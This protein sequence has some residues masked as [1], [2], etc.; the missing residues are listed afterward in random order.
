MAVVGYS[1][2][3]GSGFVSAGDAIELVRHKKVPKA[4][5]KPAFMK[6]NTS[7]TT[8]DA[9]I[10]LQCRGREIG[11]LPSDLC[12]MIAPLLDSHRIQV[13]AKCVTCAPRLD[14]LSN[15][16][17]TLEV[18]V[19]AGAVSLPSTRTVEEP[20][21]SETAFQ[22]KEGWNGLLK[23]LGLQ[24]SQRAQVSLQMFDQLKS[25][26]KPPASSSS[27]TISLRASSE[28]Q[29]N[30]EIVSVIDLDDDTMDVELS[31]DSAVELNVETID[32]QISVD[33]E[34]STD[35][36]D[37]CSAS[38]PA[39]PAMS[40]LDALVTEQLGDS[41]LPEASPVSSF[42]SSLRAYQRQ[43][44]AWMLE[45]EQGGDLNSVKSR[46]LHPMWEEYAFPLA[47]ADDAV[48]VRQMYKHFYFNP[49]SGEFSLTFPSAAPSCTGG[50]LADEMGLGKTVMMLSLIATN[51]CSVKQLKRK[52]VSSVSVAGDSPSLRT[53]ATLIVVPM[54]LLGQWK[55]E[56]GTHLGAHTVKVYEH[57][58]P[59]RYKSASPFCNFDIVLTTYGVLASESCGPQSP[60]HTIQWH[61]VILDEAHNI[62]GRT[63]Q[64]ARAAFRLHAD[65]R[66]CLTGTPVQN[67]LDDLFSLLHFL[68]VEPWSDYL[69]WTRIVCK[70][71]EGGDPFAASLLRTI[72]SPLLLRRTKASKDKSGNAIVSLPPKHIHVH[73][74]ELTTEERDFYDALFNRSKTKFDHFVAQGK[75]LSNYASILELLLRLRQ[76]CDHP[77]LTLSRGDTGAVDDIDKLMQKFV[78]RGSEMTAT[79]ISNVVQDIRSGVTKECPVCLDPVE[80]AIVTECAHVLCREC[81]LATLAKLGSCPICRK[82]LSKESIATVPRESK[83][84]I[85]VEE[86][87]RPSA[88]LTALIERLQD[89]LA[90]GEKC[91]VFSQWTSML[92]LVQ[93]PLKKAEIPFLRLDGSLS[94][95]QRDRCLAEFKTEGGPRVLLLSLK[96]GGVGLNLTAASW[97]FLLDPWWNPAIEDQAMQR[98]HRIGQSK[99][100]NVVRFIVKGTV[101]VNILKMQSRKEA[102]AQGALSLSAEDARK[103]RLEDLKML[104]ETPTT[105]D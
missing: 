80:D 32:A 94:A 18:W 37:A 103:H 77:F 69:W 64:L 33:G 56:I 38:Q 43:A 67:K 29:P 53:R 93:I 9:M 27:S 25:N 71:Y 98:V 49:L 44:L 7:G 61:R 78:Q 14:I 89:A 76:T 96:A 28:S 54:S 16:H 101:E 45:R 11:R 65:K 70:P 12:K 1:T 82:S 42:R 66:W 34:V 63:V 95:Q 21:K 100:V 86:R 51:P 75:A 41:Q 68:R 10:R 40:G 92:D 3:K 30:R 39:A 4:K 20:D 60:L 102:M 97:V 8:V 35:A 22:E 79:F 57:Y 62:K 74:V 17:L 23:R 36:A 73:Y 85:D 26:R 91:V 87:Y 5:G 13:E 104:F 48:D 59:D 46:S 31:N 84:S 83:F 90:T 58:G 81:M 6:H 55:A 88:K 47:P 19:C 72:L 50:I 2:T 15:I 24:P 52:A 99:P 105:V